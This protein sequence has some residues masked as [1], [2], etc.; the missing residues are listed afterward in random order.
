[1]TVVLLSGC[2]SVQKDSYNSDMNQESKTKAAKIALT[3]DTMTGLLLHI[4]IKKRELSIDISKWI[5]RRKT[6]VNDVMHSKIISYNENTIFQ[7]E[8]GLVVQPEDFK[9]GEKLGVLPTSGTA[10]SASSSNKVPF[11]ADKI[12]QLVMSK[13]EKLDRFLAKGD[14]FHTVVLY[15]EGTKPPYDEMDFDKYVP[16]SFSGGISWVPYVEGLAVDYK[17]ELGLEKLPMI[18][19]FDQNGTLFQTDSIEQL[20]T[21][22]DKTR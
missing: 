20:K 21:W 16:E 19:V 6:K 17:E 18:M 11:I 15:E 22:S 9:I 7:D 13:E 12:I 5:N 3:D 2:S 8:Q 10:S 4:D 1:M 14:K